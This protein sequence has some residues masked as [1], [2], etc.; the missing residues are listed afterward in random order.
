L[1]FLLLATAI[2]CTAPVI[3]GNTRY[4]T[5]QLALEA[6][7]TDI[8][9]QL[10]TINRRPYLGGSVLVYL[11]THQQMTGPPFTDR[12]IERN[13]DLYSFFIDYWTADHQGI[14]DAL[15][16]SGVFDSVELKRVDGYESFARDY[17]YR[18]LVVRTISGW[19]L[20]DIVTGETKD[21]SGPP[22][23]KNFVGRV[24]GAAHRFARDESAPTGRSA[25]P[26]HDDGLH[27]DATTRRGSLTVRGTGLDGRAQLVAAI[28]RLCSTKSVSI[29]GGEIPTEGGVFEV[30]NES[31]HQGQFEI[32]FR[33]LY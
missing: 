12:P 2:G 9:S 23:F 32:E 27:Y 20:Q 14:R 29:V 18:Y 8:A 5:K 22:G 19:D 11:P 10:G 1:A 25:S 33:C 21:V 3:Y 26:A 15:R 17:G 6:M 31:L 24:E 28:G 7:A 30:T 13:E 4:A 16:Q